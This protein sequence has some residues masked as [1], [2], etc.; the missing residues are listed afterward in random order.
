[1]RVLIT[2]G[3]GFLG[4]HLANKL[5][6]ENHDVIAVDN[7]IASKGDAYASKLIEKKNVQL[8]K[9]D[10]LKD[11]LDKELVEDLDCVIHLAAILGV[12]NVINN[13]QKAL[14]LNYRL[15]FNVL[16]ATKSTKRIKFIFAS[17]SEVYAESV[18]QGI[19]SIPTSE[20]SKITA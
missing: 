12:D 20:E 14:D 16:E 3:L 2:G 19:A 1:M 17:T 8:I 4:C 10:L 13:P 15:L 7:V 18:I 9:C 11:S 5:A 6:D